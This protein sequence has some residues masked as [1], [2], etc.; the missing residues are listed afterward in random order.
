[1]DCPKVL[2]EIEL[3]HKE[4]QSLVESSGFYSIYE[5]ARWAAVNKPRFDDMEASIGILDSLLPATKSNGLC[6][7]FEKLA[8]ALRYI[9]WE[10]SCFIDCVRAAKQAIGETGILPIPPKIKFTKAGDSIQGE[11][12]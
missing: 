4:M 1:M 2:D 11:Q 7:R 10:A 3:S 6:P 9:A 12:K 5:A 8:Y